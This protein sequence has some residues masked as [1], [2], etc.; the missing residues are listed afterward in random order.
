MYLSRDPMR[1]NL[2][3]ANQRGKSSLYSSLDAN[4][5]HL[6]HENIYMEF[7]SRFNHNRA[8]SQ[9]T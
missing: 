5:K 7:P 3:Y 4:N 6:T 8:T 9:I 2:I 1:N